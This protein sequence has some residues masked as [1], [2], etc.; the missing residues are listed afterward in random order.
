M[1]AIHESNERFPPPMCHPGTREVVVDKII[2]WYLDRS[3]QRK[4]IMW[5]HAPAGFGKTAVAGTV[6]E[7]LKARAKELG[8]DPIGASFFFWRNSPER[9]S[10]ARF[11]IT[12][13][14]QLAECISELR[15]H[16]EAAIREKPGIVKMALEHQ[17]V[18]L[19]VE[20][21]QSLV[22]LSVIP[23]RLLIIDGIDE[24]I[25][26]D[27]ESRV[28]KQYAEDQEAV[29]IRVLELIRRLHSYQLPLSFL[30]LSRREAWIKQHLESNAFRDVL[31]P[32]DLYEVGDH[33]KD[34]ATFVRAELSRIATSQGLEDAD[35][36]W[37][38][39]EALV[40]RS[41]GQM[42]YAST[43]IR[44]IDDPYGDPRQ[45]LKDI[46]DSPSST[47][48]HTPDYTP[49][50]P[51]Y[52]LYSQVMQSCPQRNRALLVEVLEDIMLRLRFKDSKYDVAL[53]IMDRLSGRTPG[54][55]VKAL[56]PLHAV[57][58][59]ASSKEKEGVG[60]VGDLI[61]HS[62]FEEFLQ[63]QHASPHFTV[64]LDKRRDRVLSRMLDCMPS[65]VSLEEAVEKVDDVANFVSLN[66]W[67]LW[68]TAMTTIS[69]ARTTYLKK[70][71][72]IDLRVSIIQRYKY[73]ENA[74]TTSFFQFFR[75]HM[76]PSKYLLGPIDR[77]RSEDGLSALDDQAISH[78][79]S[80][81]EGAFAFLL[82]PS[83]PLTPLTDKLD[84]IS[85][86]CVAYLHNIIT[87]PD[88]G[89]WRNCKLVHALGSPAGDSSV[90]EAVLQELYRQ[91]DERLRDKSNWR[92][93]SL[94]GYY[95]RRFHRGVERVCG[96]LH[97]DQQWAWEVLEHLH[98]T[99]ER[100]QN[101]ILEADC[102]PFSLFLYLRDKR[103][104]QEPTGESTQ[105]P[106]V[107][108]EE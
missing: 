19:I 76:T 103:R 41:K 54:S 100:N 77:N 58:R 65:P 60:I 24:C 5:V 29:Q 52:E 70:I 4:G 51:L 71:V 88:N 59:L 74:T 93:E 17:L 12:L 35:E 34:V 68:T 15:P 73:S 72:T 23:N 14:Y 6:T 36:E 16:V 13:A 37:E 39:E 90:F 87:Q 67:N 33:M 31:E 92:A 104:S 22:D 27:Q 89:N 75:W 8:F 85:Y 86:D 66:F 9:N 25:N 21:F 96:P 38:E 95:L 20:P 69:E 48:P 91:L 53:A 62:S 56:R 40:S 61:I 49:F 79:Q 99:M 105:P 101:P 28:K 44:H 55:G 10:P 7:T 2:V 81:F 11:I 30:L 50:S 45:L 83:I 43:V 57:L 46:I 78:W 97:K 42:I 98:E 94:T 107:N 106:V 26:S 108:A 82:Q 1:G 84:F 32:L 64:D 80:S 102:H 63:S 3:D 18:K 47:S